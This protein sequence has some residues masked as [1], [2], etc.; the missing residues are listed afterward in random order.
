[1]GKN[2]KL[3]ITSD[4]KK[5]RL[6]ITM[7][8]T[9]TKKEMGKIYTEI[10]FC[11]A[12]LKPGFD[13]VNDLSNCNIVYLDGI[14]TY[15]KII[16]YLVDYKV[17]RIIRVSAT[18]SL[19]L[20]QALAFADKFNSFKPINVDSLEEADVELSQ[21]VEQEAL[22]FHIHHRRIKYSNDQFEKNGEL[23]DFSLVG[24]AVQGE[25]EELSENI[26]LTVHIPLLHKGEEL[27]TFNLLSKV[28]N[29]EG[30]QFSVVFVDLDQERKEQLQQCLANEIR[31]EKA[32]AI[33]E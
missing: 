28:V 20:K 26:Q 17:G 7:P 30:N 8:A 15:K 18:K 16:A 12:D 4:I 22:R 25:V 19:A 27:T 29:I 13:V 33:S 6:Y 1:M 14:G 11:V 31:R 2:Q 32:L 23:V 10:R 3:K 24:C 21:P 9:V 5:N